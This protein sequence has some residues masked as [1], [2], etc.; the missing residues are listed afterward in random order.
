METQTPARTF[1]ELVSLSVS[2]LN[3]AAATVAYSDF[4]FDFLRDQRGEMGRELTGISYDGWSQIRSL[5]RHICSDSQ[6]SDPNPSNK[7]T[8]DPAPQSLSKP[9]LFT[10]LYQLKPRCPNWETRQAG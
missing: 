5:E 7:P 8:E 1:N 3:N 4:R 9:L 6:N 2:N 10:R